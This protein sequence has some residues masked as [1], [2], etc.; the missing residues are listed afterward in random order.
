[1]RDERLAVAK[2]LALLVL[3][4]RILQRHVAVAALLLLLDEVLDAGDAA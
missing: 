3:G 1:V 4:A 2:L